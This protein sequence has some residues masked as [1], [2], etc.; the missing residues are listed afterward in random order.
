MA[1]YLA[2]P[3]HQLQTQ[4]AEHNKRT[5]EI[6]QQLLFKGST[7]LEARGATSTDVS[8]EAYL[9]RCREQERWA[10]L[11][12]MALGKHNA[13]IDTFARTKERVREMA[14]KGTLTDGRTMA[15]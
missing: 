6:E 3:W 7:G 9:A 14:E 5:L 13:A 1:A 15:F 11:H 4:L 2:G 8:V 10:E 12:A